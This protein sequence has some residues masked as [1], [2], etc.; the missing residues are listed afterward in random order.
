MRNEDGEEGFAPSSYL[1]VKEEKGLPWLQAS[2]LKEE[3]EERKMRVSRLA[4]QRA[5]LEGKG[6]GPP[7]KD[8]KPVCKVGVGLWSVW[9]G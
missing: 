4:Q 9:S 6:F 7:P 5:A 2:A 8:L 1:L 3:E